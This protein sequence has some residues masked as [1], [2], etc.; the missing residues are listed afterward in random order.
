M[1]KRAVIVS[2]GT[3]DGAFALSVIEKLAPEYVIGADRGL[4]FL[5]ENQIMP[6]HIVGDF[7]SGEKEV[8]EYYRNHTSVPIQE[9]NP[10]KDA[11]DTEIALRLAIELGAKEVWL[12]GATGTRVDHVLGNIQIL[13]VAHDAGVKAYIVDKYNKISLIEKELRL[14]KEDAFGT[15]FSV[16]PLGGEVKHFKIEGAFYPLHDHTLTSYD[17]LCVS[18]QIVGELQITFPEGLVVFI[19]SRD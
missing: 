14:K 6:T 4:S 13:K 9:F 7:D 10:I 5:H 12:L 2:G 1:N 8:V 16:F 15:Y 3:I 19:E 11:T 18:N 17:S